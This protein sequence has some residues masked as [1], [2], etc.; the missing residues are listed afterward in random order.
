MDAGMTNAMVARLSLT[1]ELGYEVNV[2]V[3]GF[4]SGHCSR[5]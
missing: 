4:S 1:G 5:F 2:P 3:A